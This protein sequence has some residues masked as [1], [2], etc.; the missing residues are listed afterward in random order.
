MPSALPEA[1]TP[2]SAAETLAV[3][4]ETIDR[5]ARYL[6]RLAAWQ[7]R[8]NLVG[9]S[10][11][12]D[13]WRRHIL[14]SGQLWR[15]WPAGT[16]RLVD[17]GSGAG[18]PGLI[19]AIMGAPEVHLVESD[20]RKATFLREAARVTGCDQVT[21]HAVRVEEAALAADV[22]TARAFAPLCRLI[23]AGAHLGHTTTR[24]LLL[25]GRH[26]EAEL[27]EAQRHWTMRQRLV[28]SLADPEGSVLIL[29][30]VRR[31]ELG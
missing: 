26:V 24:W 10:T 31:D 11:L 13:P 29:E 22:I 19:L 18:L 5:F 20:R 6:E 2:E 7:K 30:E 28:P 17:L 8:I 16:R 14:D 12:D 21:V 9:R 15:H 27:T 3:S 23:E 25:K 4:R 1:L